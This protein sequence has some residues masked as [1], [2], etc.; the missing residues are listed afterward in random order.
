MTAATLRRRFIRA[1]LEWARVYASGD[2]SRLPEAYKTKERMQ[3]AAVAM[4]R[5]NGGDA[6]PSSAQ[7]LRGKR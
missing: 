3:A 1:A 6:A 5:S 4:C 7:E 2:L